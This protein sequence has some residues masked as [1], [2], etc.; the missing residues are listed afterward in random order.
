MRIVLNDKEV[1]IPS[2]LSEITLK[3]RIDFHNQYGR[4]LDEMLTGILKMEDGVEKELEVGHYHFEKMFRT[5]AFFAGTTPDAIKESK[6]IDD[7]AAIYHACLAQLFDDEGQVELKTEFAY[8]GELWE[9]SAPE[10]KN[11]SKMSFGEFVDAKQM[12][13]DMHELGKGKWESML[14]L[15]AIFLRRKGEAFQEE[16]LFEDSERLKLME[17]LPMDIAIQVG[18]FLTASLNFYL[19]TSQSFTNQESKE[20]AS[21]QRNISI[22]GGG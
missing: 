3:Q 19:N 5:F 13:K 20:V 4:E 16:F 8:K 6:F 10:I 7:I 21:T 11:G 9:L 2:A 17:D 14:R 22:S 1:I 12:V 15:C 18:F